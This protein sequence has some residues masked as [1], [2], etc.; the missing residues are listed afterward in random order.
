MDKGHK[1]IPVMVN[2]EMLQREVT[3]RLVVAIGCG[4]KVIRP[5]RHSAVIEPSPGRWVEEFLHDDLAVVFTQKTQ[6]RPTQFI[7]AGPKAFHR[8]RP[9]SDFGRICRKVQH[10][11]CKAWRKHFALFPGTSLG[12][13]HKAQPR[14]HQ[15]LRPPSLRLQPQSLLQGQPGNRSRSVPQQSPSADAHQ[16]TSTRIKT[17]RSAYASTSKLFPFPKLTCCYANPTCPTPASM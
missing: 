13:R 2:A 10:V 17:T 12:G 15:R 8:L 11:P 3:I 4:R 16:H 14:I 6:R 1:R 7:E 9:C 5:N